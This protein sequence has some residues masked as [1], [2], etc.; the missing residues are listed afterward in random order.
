MIALVEDGGG[1]DE[2]RVGAPGLQ[3][4]E[5]VKIRFAG[6]V[7]LTQE[8][9]RRL[10]WKWKK[11]AGPK[12]MLVSNRGVV[13]EFRLRKGAWIR[14]KSSTAEAQRTQRKNGGRD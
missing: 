3:E 2:S 13:W 10:R 1:K 5:W 12:L 4:R 6:V 7:R 8:V 14:K 9:P 11:G